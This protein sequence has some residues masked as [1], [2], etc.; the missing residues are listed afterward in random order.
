MAGQ[1]EVSLGDTRN[2][3]Y[4]GTVVVRGR[5]KGVVVSTG[6]HTEMGHITKMI[7]EAEDDQT[8]LQRRLEHLGKSLV[9]FCLGVCACGGSGYLAGRAHVSYVSSRC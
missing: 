7:Q 4:M 9:I 3:A 5:A 6:M 1:E 2:M 8:P